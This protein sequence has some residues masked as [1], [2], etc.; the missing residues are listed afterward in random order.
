MELHGGIHEMKV[1]VHGHVAGDRLTVSC[2]FLIPNANWGLESPNTLSASRPTRSTKTS[3]NG[4][5][6]N[7][8]SDY[9]LSAAGAAENS[10]ELVLGFRL[11]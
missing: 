4:F 6:Y 1:M 7:H 11:G 10:A 9:L 5:G 2:E 3:G 8:I